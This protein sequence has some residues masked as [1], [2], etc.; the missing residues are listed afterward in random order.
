MS[1]PY[2]LE[3]KKAKVNAAAYQ[4]HLSKQ[5]LPNL[6]KIYPDRKYIFA[7]DGATSHTAKTTQ[8]YLKERLGKGGFL[9]ST[10]W[11]PSSPDC[12][13]LDYYFWNKLSGKVY[14]GRTTPFENVEM[15]EKRIRQVW[16]SAIEMVEIRKAIQQFRRRLRAV[17]F[18]NGQPIKTLFK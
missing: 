2:F 13:V 17:V 12:N 5:L 16:K 1:K 9:K 18:S 14:E 7:Q 11:P 6:D 3:T 10:E 4:K 15:L 8:E